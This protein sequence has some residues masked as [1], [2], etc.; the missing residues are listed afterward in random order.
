MR[1]FETAREILEQFAGVFGVAYRVGLV[2][3]L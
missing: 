1:V 2:D 3:R